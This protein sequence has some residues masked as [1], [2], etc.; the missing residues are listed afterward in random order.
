MAS[1]D[2]D[3]L[4]G[5]V[6]LGDRTA[7]SELY[8]LTSAR[9]F[10]IC[11]R[12]L[13]DRVEAEDALQEVF[14]KIWRRAESFAATGNGSMGWLA[15]IARYHCIDRLRSRQPANTAIDEAAELPSLEPDPE[16]NAVARSEGARIDRCMQELDSDRALAVRSAYVE[17][18]S[19]QELADRFGVPLNTMR[20]WLRRS[21][22][23]LRECMER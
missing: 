18:A 6:A 7:F 23:T 11:L 10:G 12:M 8:R 21:L 9:L 22:L 13:R 17:G 2:V 14:V 19:Y 1:D 3:M 5:R 4:L 16:H 15:A 20:T